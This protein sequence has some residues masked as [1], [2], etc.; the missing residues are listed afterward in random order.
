MKTLR[1]GFI[2]CG[3]IGKLHVSNSKFVPG[4]DVV[5]FADLDTSR[6]DGFLQ[7]FGGEYSTTM[8]ERLIE[9]PTLDGVM[10]ATGE[11]HHPR[12]CIAAAKA[13]KHIFVEKPIAITVEEA[14]E[15]ESVVRKTGVKFM[16][17]LCNRLAPAVQRAKKCFPTPG[18]ATAN[19]PIQ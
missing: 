16:I 3:G 4:M 7:E 18:S 6:A 5:A 9:D 8:P 17:G 2:G 10:I 12:L 13:G 15:V 19:A 11:K 1:F 14:L